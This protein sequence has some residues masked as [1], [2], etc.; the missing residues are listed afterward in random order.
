MVLANID[1]SELVNNVKHE[2]EWVLAYTVKDK[3]LWGTIVL[4]TL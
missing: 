4:R 1:T 2:F 3:E